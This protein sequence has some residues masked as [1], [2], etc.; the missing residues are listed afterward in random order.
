MNPLILVDEVLLK[1][2]PKN[3]I[4]LKYSSTETKELKHCYDARNKMSVMINCAEF[5][6][7]H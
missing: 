2:E 7:R 1:S 3:L 4:Y 5:G 6:R